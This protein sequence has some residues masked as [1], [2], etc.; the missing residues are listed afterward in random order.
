MKLYHLTNVFEFEIVLY[1]ILFEKEFF[2]ILYLNMYV[3]IIYDINYIIITGFHVDLLISY[4][5]FCLL[6]HLLI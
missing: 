3:Y 5:G 4:D 1:M 6:S 2:C